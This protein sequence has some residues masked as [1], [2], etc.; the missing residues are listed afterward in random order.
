MT[1]DEAR[2]VLL[3]Q[4]LFQAISTI[5]FLDGCLLYPKRYRYSYPKQTQDRL[6]EFEKLVKPKEFCVHSMTVPDCPG[7]QQRVLEFIKRDEALKTLGAL[8]G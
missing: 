1:K 6:R 8:N 7:C 5:E 3:E 2:I 4:A